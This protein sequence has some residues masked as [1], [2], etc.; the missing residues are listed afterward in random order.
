MCSSDLRVAQQNVSIGLK[1]VCLLGVRPYINLAV[2][3]AFAVS[4]HDPFVHF[5][6]KRVWLAVVHDRMVISQ[7]IPVQQVEA[8]EMGLAPFS[9]NG[10]SKIIPD[11]L[12]THRE[13]KG[14][15]PAGIALPDQ[16]IRYLVE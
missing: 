15:D 9:I 6:A 13:T 7:C 10:N 11:Q 3:N 5:I 8:I 4:V 14:V 2:E 16:S 12:A 1:S